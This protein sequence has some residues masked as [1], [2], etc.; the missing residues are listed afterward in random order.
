MNLFDKLETASQKGSKEFRRILDMQFAN[1]PP[2]LTH[3]RVT[4]D[5]YFWVIEWIKT[6]K[7]IFDPYV[8]FQDI[9]EFGESQFYGLVAEAKWAIND[10]QSARV[11]AQQALD[12]DPFYAPAHNLMNIMDY[13]N[14]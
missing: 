10:E 4:K 8:L 2:V 5:V 6:T 1:S 13:N 12:F 14:N 3:H 11:A 9:R 7:R